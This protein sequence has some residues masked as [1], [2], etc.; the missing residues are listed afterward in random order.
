M[1][2]SESGEILD[3]WE[4]IIKLSQ[5][6]KIAK[7]YKPGDYKSF[8]LE[9]G[10][11]EG[12]VCEMGYVG[13]GL[14]NDLTG[15]PV[16][17]WI[18][19]EG[20]VET[21]WYSDSDGPLDWADSDIRSYCYNNIYNYIPNVIRESIELVKKEYIGLKRSLD[22]YRSSSEDLVWILSVDECEQLYTD[23]IINHLQE[24]NYF[25][26]RD[27]LPK[28]GWAR[29]YVGKKAN[30]IT[31]TNYHSIGPRDLIFGFCISGK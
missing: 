10:P 29:V 2:V 9:G 7:Y 25:W 21:G 14:E 27:A 4:K 5:S 8:V 13:Y 31:I 20:P 22:S 6:G 18:I 28:Y 16:S 30:P 26:L 15:A 23:W 3:D 11:L 1:G 24:E 19:K 12:T 17:T